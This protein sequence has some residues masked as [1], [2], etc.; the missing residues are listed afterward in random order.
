MN[1]TTPKIYEHLITFLEL[2]KFKSSKPGWNG[3]FCLPNEYLL[4]NNLVTLC[5]GTK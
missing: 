4:F 2:E 5:Y 3:A 1:E